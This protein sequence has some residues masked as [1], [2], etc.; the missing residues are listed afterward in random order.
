MN[1]L[2]R[3]RVAFG[4]A[5]YEIPVWQRFDAAEEQPV[6]FRKTNGDVLTI[7]LQRGQ[8]DALVNGYDDM[9]MGAFKEIRHRGL[10]TVL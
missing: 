10:R 9:L 7:T 2:E 4:F 1:G 8:F 3:I 5:F 6:V